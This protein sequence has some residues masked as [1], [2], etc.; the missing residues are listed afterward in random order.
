MLGKMFHQTFAWC[1]VE[2]QRVPPPHPPWVESC[3]NPSHCFEV[4]SRDSLIC[5]LH[6]LASSAGLVQGLIAEHRLL[7]TTISLISSLDNSPSTSSSVKSE[8][9]LVCE[10]WQVSEREVSHSNISLSN[11]QWGLSKS[12][13]AWPLNRKMIVIEP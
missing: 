9:S 4:W 10:M 5:F 11:T 8:M 13:H 2:G 7:D 1:V 6:S 12:H 3:Q